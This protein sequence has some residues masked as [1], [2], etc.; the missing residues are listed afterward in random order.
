[1]FRFQSLVCKENKSLAVKCAWTGENIERVGCLV[2]TIQ[3][4][5]MRFEEPCQTAARGEVIENP[6]RS[7]ATAVRQEKTKVG[8]WLTLALLLMLSAVQCFGI[9]ISRGLFF[10]F[11]AD[12]AV[13]T[14][15]D[16]Q[17]V[18]FFY[19]VPL[20]VAIVLFIY[21]KWYFLIPLFGSLYVVHQPNE[22]T[23]GRLM[24]Y[25]YDNASGITERLELLGP[26]AFVWV[27]FR[28]PAI[29]CVLVGL[30]SWLNRNSRQSIAATDDKK[31]GSQADA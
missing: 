31:H 23:F 7:S 30:L 13:G 8:Y 17:W 15:K 2:V 4:D 21:R 19:F 11:P 3:G 9:S 20:V 1:V 10:M 22:A 24:L 6:Y 16:P 27:F 5:L 25:W 26:T 29:T 18:A 28:L 12:V 14:A